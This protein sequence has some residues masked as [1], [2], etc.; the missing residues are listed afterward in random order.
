[1]RK[2]FKT[3]PL[4]IG[5]ADL[6]EVFLLAHPTVMGWAASGVYKL[7]TSSSL[8]ELA[9]MRFVERGGIQRLLHFLQSG[10]QSVSDRLSAARAMAAY[11]HSQNSEVCVLIVE[12][13]G[14]ETVA[15]LLREDA[16]LAGGYAGFLAAVVVGLACLCPSKLD[17][18]TVSAVVQPLTEL[19]HIGDRSDK[20]FAQEALSSL[21]QCATFPFDGSGEQEQLPGQATK[22]KALNERV[23][24]QLGEILD[25]GDPESRHLAFVLLAQLAPS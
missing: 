3:R 24:P 22:W 9:A 20:K 2:I 10:A 5:V 25:I 13:G 19:L 18:M 6:M 15:G 11:V 16:A 21:A 7:A 12:A 14:F 1:L 4:V 17:P 23:I 8:A